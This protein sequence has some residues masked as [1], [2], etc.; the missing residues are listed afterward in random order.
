M[1][2]AELIVDLRDVRVVGDAGVEVRA[3]RDDSR[4]VERGDVFV[5]VRGLTVDGHD[6][7]AT[8][9]GRGAAAVVVERE[10]AG[11]AVPQVVVAHGARA[12]GWLAE[13][14]AGRPSDRMVMVGIT[15][16]NGKTTTTFVLESMVAPAD[17][18]PGVIGTVS[19]RFGGRTIEAPF[20]TP[21]PIA[22][23]GLFGDML[24]AGTSHVLMETSSAALAMERLEGVGFQVGA[25]SNLTQDHL[26]VHGTME[27]YF[28]AKQRLFTERLVAGGAAVAM[29]DDAD[30][31]GERMLSAA[32]PGVRRIAVSLRR[33]DAEVGVQA[34]ESSIGGIKA[35]LRTP[36]GALRVETAALFGEY[37]LANLALAVGVGEALGLPHEA[38]R[39]G[40]ARLPGVPGRVERVQN[41][42]GLD[43]FV[44]YAHTPDALERAAHRGVRLRRG[45]RSRQA[46]QDGEDR[47][48]RGRPGGGHVGQS[49]HRGAGEDHRHGD[50][51]GARSQP[52]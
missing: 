38:M 8:A 23:A 48:R 9:V 18:R 32:A 6:F 31:H 39:E 50:R 49:A 13:R 28:A 22:L 47:R 25:F 43:V 12:L 24:A 3:V 40:I 11:L 35:T 44:D 34:A 26:D 30:G 15:G 46:A 33:G 36:R 14:V 1:R 37:N 10:L 2:L 41:A 27:A 19:Y 42:R 52:A 21:T 45:S 17:G 5:A 4:Q 16:T 29:V 51:G 7:V 20:T